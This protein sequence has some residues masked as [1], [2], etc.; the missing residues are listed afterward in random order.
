MDI[1]DVH[2]WL[3]NGK[4]FILLYKENICAISSSKLYLTDGHTIILVPIAS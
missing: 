4:L 3:H 1:S 2:A